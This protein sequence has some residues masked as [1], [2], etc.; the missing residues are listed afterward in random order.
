[1][2]KGENAFYQNQMKISVIRIRKHCGKIFFDFNTGKSI[3]SHLESEWSTEPLR[4][5]DDT[6]RFILIIVSLL[7]SIKLTCYQ[8]ENSIHDVKQTN[9]F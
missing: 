5:T 1:M 3:F 8:Y 4:R 9:F 2:G 6:N 7:C